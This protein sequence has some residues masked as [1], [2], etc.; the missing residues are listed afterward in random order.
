MK[1]H[2]PTLLLAFSITFLASCSSDDENKSTCNC[3]RTTYTY[4][5]MAEA[6]EIIGTTYYSDNCDDEVT[7]KSQTAEGEI[8]TIDCTAN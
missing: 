4:D 1:K 2:L 6:Y 3:E 7:T 8:Y 5:N